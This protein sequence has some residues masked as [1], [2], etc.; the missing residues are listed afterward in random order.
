MLK[1]VTVGLAALVTVG[2]VSSAMALDP[3][4]LDAQNYQVDINIEVAEEVSMWAGHPAANLLLEGNDANNFDGFESSITH[5]NNTA[6]NI[7]VAVNGN[8]PTPGVPGGGVLFYIFDG[9]DVA[10]AQAA[11]LANAYAPANAL[12]WTDGTE[13]TSQNFDTNIPAATSANTRQVT[14]AAATPGELPA[15]Q[16][17][18]LDVVWTIS[19]ATP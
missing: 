9:V 12:V 10:T 16:A 2:F 3:N 5:I 17:F 13:G 7:D 19:D 15:P 14:Y 6:A 11:T 1:K 8:L 4:Q 18:D